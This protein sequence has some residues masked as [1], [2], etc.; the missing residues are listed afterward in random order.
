MQRAQFSHLVQELVQPDRCGSSS[1]HH[2][3]IHA[4]MIFELS[5]D[6]L[7]YSS[8][9]RSRKMLTALARKLRQLATHLP[10]LGDH[11]SETCGRPCTRAVPLELAN[12]GSSVRMVRRC[13]T[14]ASE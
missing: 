4:L 7:I 10:V 5:E 1:S 13:T 9:S 14:V 3:C 8:F 11:S 12:R 6:E 2:A